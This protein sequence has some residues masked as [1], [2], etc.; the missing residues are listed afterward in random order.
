[1]NKKVLGPVEL[2]SSTVNME[3]IKLQIGNTIRLKSY[4]GRDNQHRKPLRI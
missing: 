2:S 3:R 4:S 1:M